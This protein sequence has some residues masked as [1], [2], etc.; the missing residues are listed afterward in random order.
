MS[1]LHKFR[2]CFCFAAVM[3]CLATVNLSAALP[4]GSLDQEF[5]DAVQKRDVTKIQT[6]LSKGANINA[7]EPINGHFALQYAI[8]WPDASLVKLLLDKGADVNTADKNGYTALTDAVRD[9]GAEFATIA[10]LLIDRG[11]DVHANHDAAIFAAVRNAEPSVVRLLLKKGAPV[12]AT[13][14]GRYDETVLM[15]AAGGWSVEALQMVLDAGADL[16]AINKNGE[17]ALMK[18]STIDNRYSV[19]TRLPMIELLLKKGADVNARD[20]GGR[21]ALLHSVVQHMSEAGGVISHP[22]VVR[23]LLDHGADVKAKDRDGN[24]ALIET[25]GVWEGPIEIV[26]LLL[27]RGVDVD[28]QNNKG[29]SALMVAADKGKM[30]VVQLLSGKGANLNLKDDGGSTALDYAVE[31]GNAEVATFLR[32]KGA[33]SSRNYKDDSEV[34]K[35]TRGFALLRATRFNRLD[36]IKTLLAEGVDVNT[37]DNRNETAL[38]LTAQFG[39]SG[40]DILKLLLARGADVDAVNDNG[41]TA[42]MWTA[43]RN[44]GDAAEALLAGKAGVNFRNKNGQTA[45]HIAATGFHSDIVEALIAHGA[46]VDARDKDGRTP[47][48]LAGN[49]GGTV[50]D[51]IMRPLLNKGADLNAQDAMGNSALIMAAQSGGM[52]GVEFLLGKGARVD[53]RNKDGMTALKYARKLHEN[54]RIYSAK[55]VEER[56][57][58]L[59]VKAGAKE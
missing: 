25:V 15:A 9:G 14:S 34:L 3:G 39:Y 41:E 24:T 49:S 59:L 56:I 29:T 36:E 13:D 4:Q 10:E 35:A 40:I 38:I 21:T 32:A 11:A 7:K 30:D 54:E 31:N 45:L 1:H 50:P 46:E 8:N 17:T 18:A 48:I 6:L 43:Q 52:A 26:R 28:A 44:D 33:S 53:L 27:E 47:L 2:L 58:A 37:R 42:L 19:E 55:I 12:N 20:Q 57:V 5:L 22:E 23:L 51:D 16:K